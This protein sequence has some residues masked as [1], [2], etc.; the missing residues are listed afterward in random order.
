MRLIW[1]INL[2][3]GEVTY[4]MDGIKYLNKATADSKINVLAR[5]DSMKFY[6]KDNYLLINGLKL[7]FAG[8]VEMPYDDIGMNLT[9]KTDQTSFKSLLS[10]IPAVYSKD[11]KD[12][13][14]SGEFTL[15]GSAKGVYSDVDSTLPDISLN[16]KVANGLIKYSSLP[17]QI[18]NISLKSV[19]FVDG[20]DMDKTTVKVD[21]FHMEVS[22]NPFDMS[23][24]LKT[25]MSDPD[26]NGSMVGR[27]DLT[28]L[29]ESN[30]T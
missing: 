26:F 15:N 4:I 9:F 23:F 1:Q 28:S 25:P 27:I 14:A 7:N 5:L 17:E 19:V 12:L 29:I 8:M 18:K 3:A 22:G 30:S 2:D 11:F 6:L 10:L 24:S 16:L 20:K 13:Q 21:G